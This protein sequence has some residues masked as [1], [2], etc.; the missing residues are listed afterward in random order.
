MPT[1]SVMLRPLG[2]LAGAPPP[3]PTLHGA[4][5][6]ATAILFG[7]EQAQRMAQELT[8]TDAFPLVWRE[9]EQPLR[10]FPLPVLAPRA[11]S[12]SERSLEG[13]RD[14]TRALNQQK[15]LKGAR[16][17]SE[18]LFEQIAQG[19]L[20]LERL[21]VLLAE[22][23]VVLQSGCLMT[24]EE[25]ETV[26]KGSA[27]RPLLTSSDVVHNE[28]D[29]WTLAVAEGRLFL[30]EE[31]FF[32]PGVGLWFAVHLPSEELIRLLPALLRFLEDTGVGGERTT[33][34][35]HFLYRLDKEAFSLP[36]PPDANA[37]VSLSHYL[38]TPDEIQSW[39]Q[40]SPAPRYRLVAWQARYEAMFAGGEVVYKPLRRLF[41][42]CSVFPLAEKQEIY[43]RAVP[44]GERLGHTVWVCGRALPA[45]I[46][47]G[48]GV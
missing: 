17:L 40:R 32:A 36:V 38:P 48:G 28:I 43:G 26:D 25:A 19:N 16:Y 42:P 13:K 1:A 33:G 41:A 9:G 21:G 45:F 20:P 4:L 12:S 29:R 44:S 30:R 23:Q 2:S 22:Q 24:R 18:R 15:R 11:A 31:T 37:W 39:Q 14:A 47:A 34:K 3:S 5:C 46:R 10:F 7:E 8:C 6:W 35:G 27:R